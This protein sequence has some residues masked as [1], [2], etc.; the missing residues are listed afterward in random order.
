MNKR[1]LLAL[2]VLL[3][4]M[5]ATSASAQVTTSSLRGHV[6]DGKD[7]L[8]AASVQAVHMP[9]GTKYNALTNA[10]GD[11]FINNMRIGGPYTVTIS[12]IGY[13]N[14]ITNDIEL[15]LGDPFIHN[16]VM[17]E[18]AEV[19]GEVVVTAESNNPVF[20]S[21]RTGAMTAISAKELSEMP[22]VS[23]SITDFTR[24]TPQAMG[25][26]FGGRDGRMNNITIDGGA[27]R[28]NFGLSDNLM[29]GG[30][31]Q[32]IS[33]DA[34]EAV[35]VNI[36]PF[37][38]RLSGFTGASV[39]AVTKSGTNAFRGSAYT[40]HRG[41]GMTGKKVGDIEVANFR[42]ANEQTYGF[43]VGGPIIKDKLFFF[44]NAEYGAEVKPYM[45]FH[46]STDGVAKKGEN[47]SR[48]TEADLQTMK[49]F[50]MSRYNYDAGE[51]KNFPS[52][53][54]K[55]YKILA[56]IDWNINDNHQ[57]SLRYN[58]LNNRSTS[59]TSSTSGPFRFSSGRISE[60]GIAFSNSFYT[61]E[62]VI[63]GFA[64][65]LNS[66]FGS[67]V[68]NKFM[69]TYTGTEDPKRKSSSKPFPFVD[70]MNGENVYMSFGY[71]LFS[72]R[73]RV[74]NNTFSVSDDV[75]VSKGRH[76]LLAGVRYDNIFVGNG[77][78]PQG[79][80]YY[81]YASMQDF[82][83]NQKPTVFAVTYGYNGKDPDPVKM[84]FGLIAA[85][86]Q[87]DIN[88]TSNFKLSAGVRFEVPLYLNK[89][90]GNPKID[91]IQ[92]LRYD[93]QIDLSTWPK[94]QLL[95]NPRIGFN[96]DVMGDRS[97]QLRGGT[98]VFSGLMPFVWFTNQPTNSGVMQ[99][100][101]ISWGAKD[102]PN[103]LR[104]E[105]NFRDIQKKYPALFPDEFVPTGDFGGTFAMVDKNFK[106][107]QVWRTN[108]AADFALPGKTILTLEWLYS[109][110]INSP[111][112]RNVN[113]PE[114][115]GKTSEGRDL[116]PGRRI[117]KNIDYGMILTNTNKGYQTSITTQIRNKG[118]KGLDL[119]LAYTYSL[120]KDVTSNPGSRA[121]SAW[122]SNL[123]YTDIND[124]ELSYS[125]FAVPHRVLGSATYRIEYG[126]FGATTIGLYYNGA[127][128]GRYSVFTGK[129]VNNDGVSGDLLYIPKVEEAE[130]MFS[131]KMMD[132]A[133]QAKAFNEFIDG[134]R[135]LRTRRGTFAERFAQ[136]EP[137]H[138]R[139]DLKLMQEF[140][141]NFGTDRRYTVQVSLDF[142]NFGNL[143][144]SNWGVYKR[145]KLPSSYGNVMPLTVVSGG[146]T[147]KYSLN[148]KSVEDFRNKMGWENTPFVTSTWTM[149]L[150]VRLIF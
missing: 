37:D 75:T 4:S 77:Y 67:E 34:I 5:I 53:D 120:A 129:D 105:P 95:V 36:A 99:S 39:N 30:S 43:S 138:N 38:V 6:T 25:S 108:F 2:F 144:N 62:N 85:Y 115:I 91:G 66:K 14:H 131:D 52:M 19:L 110:D 104:F 27:F 1:F 146:A 103:D 51:Y 97:I 124:P 17:K 13:S 22:T 12:F 137:W 94:A 26:S 47:I 93:Q 81:R 101:E 87:D 32:P 10:N 48:T 126:K 132:P 69:I 59:L 23:R 130:A 57:L 45:G 135:Y 140:F 18:D 61:N 7:V 21:A 119:M 40:Y 125:N 139:F 136:L 11:F 84:N 73:N 16:V 41:K 123:Y 50:L 54:Q 122:T 83:N 102:I 60:Y 127:H 9:S 58:Y 8:I 80:S 145:S 64:G 28:N 49:D 143:L 89:L 78:I 55:N 56:K 24:L 3:A 112:Q 142:L 86:F 128:Q 72:Y 68:S 111:L 109:K 148:A 29:P 15:T 31:A 92:G 106:M 150:G 116:Y 79:T 121:Q 117:K 82:M 90:M 76:T 65:E 133:E 74:V 42:D 147:P 20:N 134:D 149:Q 44:V 141:T 114:P 35:S 88:V 96:W 46:P 71:E 33:L 70:I 100:P 113:L 98:G 63:H 107:P 118:V